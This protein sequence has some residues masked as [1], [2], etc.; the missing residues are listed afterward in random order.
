[1]KFLQVIHTEKQLYYLDRLQQGLLMPSIRMCKLT[2]TKCRLEV[3]VPLRTKCLVVNR[4][5]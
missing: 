3:I 2:Q 4:N 1:M 5:A